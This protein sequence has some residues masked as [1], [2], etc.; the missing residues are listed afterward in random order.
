VFVNKRLADEAGAGQFLHI[1]C[2]EGIIL[3]RPISI[4]DVQDAEITIVFD[5]RGKGT[6]WLSELL[7]GDT[8]DI[9]GPLGNGF[10]LPDGDVILV[11]GGVGVPPLLYAAKSIQGRVTSILGFRDKDKMLLLDAFKNA[12]EEV[13]VTTD[14]GSYGIHGT[15]IRPLEPLLKDG[16]FKAVLTCGTR[17]MMAAVAKLCKQ[18][19][20]PC[21]VSLEER[22]GCGV[23]ACLVCACETLKN[24][25]QH[26][27]HVCIDGPVFDARNV[28]W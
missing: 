15:V 12:C 27:S 21:Q 13:Y 23:G 5:V 6:L 4:A 22:M 9:L 17:P 11:G 25:V 7:A 26:M 28:V 10:D 2:G 19:D 20:L 24:G 3:R 8:L 16:R 18:Y 14:D 1:K